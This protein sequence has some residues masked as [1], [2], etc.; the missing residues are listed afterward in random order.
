MK[1]DVL[2]PESPVALAAII[3]NTD[4]PV[5]VIG[6]GSKAGIGLPVEDGTLLV[7]TS[8]L[9]DVPYF[10]PS[11]FV[12]AAQAG[13]KVSDL[14]AKLQAHDLSLPFHHPWMDNGATLGGVIAT[15]LGGDERLE[16]GAPRDNVLGVEYINGRGEVLRA[17]GRVMKNVTGLDMGRALAGSWG[18]LAV[19]TEI[20]IKVVPAARMPES[21]FSLSDDRAANLWRISVPAAHA[22]QLHER[23]GGRL[24]ACRWDGGLAWAATD[25]DAWDGHAIA[26]EF[27]GHALRVRGQ[28]KAFQPQYSGIKKLEAQVKA[29]LDPRS[30]FDS[31]YDD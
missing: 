3:A 28:G 11:E 2:T 22:D 26:Q 7:S 29:A 17:G 4:A 20:A 27:H 24:V 6:S 1:N 18:R 21:Q 19:L 14:Q 30:I 15:N 8:K 16:L 31:Q 12:V 9:T 25:D 5:R 13:V 23:L 10:E